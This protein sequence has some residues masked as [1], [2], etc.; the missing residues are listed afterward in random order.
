[1]REA[2]QVRDRADRGRAAGGSTG[3]GVAEWLVGGMAGLT[4]RTR[5]C[6]HFDLI[7]NRVQVPVL[8]IVKE[9]DNNNRVHP[10]HG[11]RFRNTTKT[12]IVGN[13]MKM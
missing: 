6:S 9:K 8:W 4:G 1:M 13:F 5:K 2:L 12:E 11:G 7:H 10:G 3:G